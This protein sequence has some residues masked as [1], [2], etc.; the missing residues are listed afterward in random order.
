M[1]SKIPATMTEQVDEI[2][3]MDISYR[4]LHPDAIVIDKYSSRNIRIPFS[5]ITNKYKDALS[6]I[7]IQ[8]ELTPLEEVTYSFKPK[9]LSYDTYGTTE[10]W[11]DMLVINDAYSVE[12]FRLSGNVNIYDPTK[13]KRLLNEIMILENL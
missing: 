9:M 1:A 7:I 10:F 12:N 4:V 3:S 8:K 11:N 6:T 13:F 2:K 5:S